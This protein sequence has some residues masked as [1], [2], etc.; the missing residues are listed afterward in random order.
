MQSVF[1]HDPTLHDNEW[2][3][4]SKALQ[5]YCHDFAPACSVQMWELWFVTGPLLKRQTEPEIT[6]RGIY[7]AGQC[8]CV[9]VSTC[10]C[11]CV[12]AHA[13]VCVCVGAV[14]S[15]VMALWHSHNKC[16]GCSHCQVCMVQ[17]QLQYSTINYITIYHNIQQIFSKW[18]V[19]QPH[20][21]MTDIIPSS[22]TD[23][24]ISLYSV[25]TFNQ[26]F[27]C[28]HYSTPS[29]CHWQ[30]NLSKTSVSFLEVVWAQKG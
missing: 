12:W 26:H 18:R 30:Q 2:D 4:C 13:R 3:L 16:Q 28:E 6:S 11:V 27:H 23:W 7:S 10:A 29:A 19:Q 5:Y 1:W 14:S 17:A 21:C 15:W 25:P 20:L 24:W 8:V 22:C 9:C